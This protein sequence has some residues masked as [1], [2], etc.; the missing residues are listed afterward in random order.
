M[1]WKVAAPFILLVAWPA[2]AEGPGNGL[3]VGD[4]IGSNQGQTINGWTDWGGG[5][6]ASAKS[7]SQC[8]KRIFNK[9]NIFLVAVTEQV[10]RRAQGGV[11]AE[12]ILATKVLSALPGEEMQTCDLLWLSPVISFYNPKTKMI[13]SVIYNGAEFVEIRYLMDGQGASCLMGD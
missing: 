4:V 5:E 6:F 9:G 2:F 10:A 8:C 7:N 3:R 11:I 13:R 1:I 12:R